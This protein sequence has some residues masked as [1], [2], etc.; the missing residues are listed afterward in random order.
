VVMLAC[1][2]SNAALADAAGSFGWQQNRSLAGLNASPGW[3]CKSPKPG[4]S[5]LRLVSNRAAI[6]EKRMILDL[7]RIPYCKIVVNF[8]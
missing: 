8:A 6:T 3:F 4:A 2:I 1:L 5:A 7:P